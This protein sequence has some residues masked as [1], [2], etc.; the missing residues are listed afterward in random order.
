M[1]GL[2]HRSTGALLL[3]LLLGAASC[4]GRSRAPLPLPPTALAA[5]PEEGFLDAPEALSGAGPPSLPDVETRSLANGMRLIV[6]RRPDLPLASVVLVSRSGTSDDRGVAPGLDELLEHVLARRAHD[7][8]PTLRGGARAHVSVASMG[9]WVWANGSSPRLET[10][11]ETIAHV[12]RDDTFSEALVRSERRLLVDEIV[13]ASRSY[14]VR[15]RSRHERMLMYGER[16]PRAGHWYGTLDGFR[17]LGR[18]ALVERHHALFAPSASALVVVGD[19][20]VEDVARRFE[21]RFSSWDAEARSAARLPPAE[22]PTPA[23]RL[24]AFP[25]SGPATIALRER[26]PTR[27]HSDRPAFEVV[28]AML[29][30]MFGARINR[31][32]REERGHTYGVHGELNDARTYAVLEIELAV[33]S[34]HVRQTVYDL[35]AE[36]RRVQDAARIEAGELLA[37]QA[38]AMAEHRRSLS[39]D[40]GTAYLLAG[41]FLR[42]E[43]LAQWGARASAIRDVDAED[44]ARAAR[45]WLRPDAAPLLV[46]GDYLR[47]MELTTLMPGGGELVLSY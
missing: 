11:L 4:G 17:A 42:D 8:A 10:M 34:A 12:A 13:D 39:T 21:A 44:V 7:R 1:R 22:F 16:D 26:A 18:P 43:T 14:S 9:T 2:A 47:M 38:T 45:T 29:G 35:I 3:A 30:G 28:T 37:A 41:L 25:V 24:H 15:V 33:P 19:V 46:S 20:E 31:V 23:A 27:E 32:L 36:L 5:T 40:A 6:V